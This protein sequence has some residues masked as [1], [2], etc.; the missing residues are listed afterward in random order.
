MYL[1]IFA[2][3]KLRATFC[4]NEQS[5]TELPESLNSVTNTKRRGRKNYIEKRMRLVRSYLKGKL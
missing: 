3:N 2:V 5:V 4:C 1:N